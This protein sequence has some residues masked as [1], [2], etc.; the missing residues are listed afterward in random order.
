MRLT[1]REIC[2]LL[3]TDKQRHEIKKCTIRTMKNWKHPH[4]S[5]WHL[6]PLPRL[7]LLTWHLPPPPEISF[8]GIFLPVLPQGLWTR[9][10]C[11]KTTLADNDVSFLPFMH[12]TPI[13]NFPSVFA[14]GCPQA[15]LTGIR[16]LCFPMQAQYPQFPCNTNSSEFNRKHLS[17]SS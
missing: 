14:L 7:L 12:L 17:Q 8:N 6:H 5:P 1:P 2:L 10:I 16:V 13:T 3:N 15:K 11:H 9:P 4:R